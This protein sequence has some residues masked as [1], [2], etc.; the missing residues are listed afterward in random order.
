[1]DGVSAAVLCASF[2]ALGVIVIVSTA[3][4]RSLALAGTGWLPPE[5]PAHRQLPLHAY[6]LRLHELEPLA[7]DTVA[8]HAAVDYE[9]TVPVLVRDT[10]ASEQ[11][12][13][14]LGGDS[15]ACVV[16]GKLGRVAA[17][18]PGAGGD[19]ADGDTRRALEKIGTPGTLLWFAEGE[20]VASPAVGEISVGARE[21][22]AAV[23]AFSP[24]RLIVLHDSRVRSRGCP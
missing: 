22:A 14:A 20:D 23:L 21:A 24:A 13:L 8:L 16:S 5:T 9:G 12:V 2:V 3:K 15:R 7:R 6:H 17:R 1:M 18:R 4:M 11:L 19:L 10:P